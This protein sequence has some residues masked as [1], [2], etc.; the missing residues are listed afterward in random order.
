MHGTVFFVFNCKNI[1]IFS[2]GL[3]D[4]NDGSDESEATCAELCDTP[5]LW[6]SGGGCIENSDLEYVGKYD[7]ITPPV[8]ESCLVITTSSHNRGNIVIGLQFLNQPAVNVGRTFLDYD[9]TWTYC[10][11]SEDLVFYTLQNDDG[12]SWTGDV[13]ITHT[14]ARYDALMLCENCDCNCE[15]DHEDDCNQECTAQQT[16]YMGLDDDS[17]V[18]GDTKCL[19]S[20]SCPFAVSWTVTGEIV[21]ICFRYNI[22]DLTALESHR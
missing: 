21:I 3:V 7:R 13:T 8:P 15:D 16:I 12:K 4:C 10:F 14:D 17:N 11:P 20:R 5:S 18:D 6:V 9:E 22:K 19:H 1:S 2:D